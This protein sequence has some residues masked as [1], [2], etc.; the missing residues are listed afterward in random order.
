MFMVNETGAPMNL[1]IRCA[2]AAWA[3]LMSAPGWAAD[4]DICGPAR[5]TRGMTVQVWAAAQVPGG[6]AP[7]ACSG[8]AEH[9]ARSLIEIAGHLP[10]APADAVLARFGAISGT[11]GVRF[12]SVSHKEWQT[13]ITAAHATD[14]GGHA[15]ADFAPAEMQPGQT[16]SYSQTDNGAGATAQRM[17]IRTVT[18]DRI[19]LTTENVGTIRLLLVPL[20]GPGELQT[21]YVL[22]RHADGWAY[23]SLTR[24]A[25]DASG[26]TDGHTDSGVNR[27][28]AMYRHMAGIPGDQEPPAAR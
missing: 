23:R 18:A 4:P 12:W 28:V 21:L 27:A 2:L 6:W 19:V 24:T 3:M 15:R 26:L 25:L 16:L 22:D 10:P 8:W 9:G 7:P 13:L 1:A 17:H 11:V 5:D 14:A 20:F